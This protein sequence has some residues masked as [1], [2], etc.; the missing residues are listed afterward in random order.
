MIIRGLDSNGDWTFGSGKSNYL[1]NDNAIALNINT[2]LYSWLNDCFFD[3][4]AGIDWKNRLGSLGQE[5]LLQNDLKRIILQSYGVTGI[6]AFSTSLINRQ[7][8]AQYQIN[9]IFSQNYIN[10]INQNIGGGYVS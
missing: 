9:T 10:S 5:T 8:N 6:T 3:T 4:Q 1:T 7:F 2:R